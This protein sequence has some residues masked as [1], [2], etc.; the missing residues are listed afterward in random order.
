M[1]VLFFA[2]CLLLLMVL[3]QSFKKDHSL[4]LV[5]QQIKLEEQAR[6]QIQETRAQWE[7]IDREKDRQ[8]QY[9]LIR[10]SM[11]QVNTAILYE[12]LNKLPNRYNE[13]AKIINTYVNADLYEYFRNL[14]EQPDN[15]Y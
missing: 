4:D 12:Q 10:D 11:A 15:E 6:K 5:K 13:K 9:G 2:V 14:P 1:V 3:F 7:Q 8:I